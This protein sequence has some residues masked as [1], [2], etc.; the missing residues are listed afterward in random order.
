M[1]QPERLLHSSGSACHSNRTVS[2]ARELLANAGRM[3]LEFQTAEKG[4]TIQPA[5]PSKVSVTDA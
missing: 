3:R 1:V 4:Q 2:L 5:S